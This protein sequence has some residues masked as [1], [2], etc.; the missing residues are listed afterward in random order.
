MKAYQALRLI[1]FKEY[2]IRCIWLNQV[3]ICKVGPKDVAYMTFQFG[4]L[5]LAYQAIFIQL[6][7]PY[8]PGYNIRYTW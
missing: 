2:N 3:P 7:G 4:F 5:D 8:L 6:Y 1:S